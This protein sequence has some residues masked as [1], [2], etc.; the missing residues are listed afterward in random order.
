MEDPDERGGAGS[1]RIKTS[2][3]ATAEGLPVAPSMGPALDA[4]RVPTDASLLDSR[5]LFICVLAIGVAIAAGFVAQLL[6]GLIGL[7]TNLVFHQRV[8]TEFAAPAGHHLGGRMHSWARTRLVESQRRELT[9][10]LRRI[11]PGRRTARA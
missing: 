1:G 2:A 11:R 3:S 5:V 9:V 4:A 8:S 6:T 10:D 7:I